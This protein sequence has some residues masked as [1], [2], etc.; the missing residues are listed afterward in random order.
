MPAANI[1]NKGYMAIKKETTKGSI[2]GVPDIYVPFYEENII[3]NVNLDED[4]PVIGNLYARYQTILGLRSHGGDFKALAEP[5]TAGYLLDMI[6]KKGSTIAGPPHTHPFT[7]ST[8]EPNSYTVDI[9]KGQL[10]ARFLGCELSE[11]GVEFDKNKMVFNGK[12]HALKSFLVREVLSISGSGPYTITF[13]TNYDQ[14]P[15]TGLI[16]GDLIRLLKADG[17]TV[18][19]VVDTIENSAA[20]TVSENVSSGAAGDLVYL[21]AGTPSYTLKAPFT[22]GRTEFRFG[23][24]AATALSAT[25][26]RVEDGSN[27]NLTYKLEADEGAQ[28][29]GSPDPAAL[30]RTLGDIEL[31]IKKFFDTP[32]DL[33]RYLTNSKRA[34]VI[35]HFSEGTDYELRVTINNMKLAEN[36]PA[37]TTKEVVYAELKGLPVY[38]DSD[39][40]GFDIKVINNVASI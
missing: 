6:L 39:A 30:V 25:Q 18:D 35:R 14:A 1:G 24:D 23:V 19:A 31:S 22:W 33:N 13:K 28:R 20:I 17:T 34:L 10:V 4:T 27:W 7:L 15:T 12:L 11:L 40:Q 9:Q 16:V 2:A 36:P 32:E 3:T 37:V 5:N 21:R 8:S 29:S 26:E 38:D